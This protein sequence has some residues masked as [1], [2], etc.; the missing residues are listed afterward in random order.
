MKAVLPV[1]FALASLTCTLNP[2]QA[3]RRG[4]HAADFGWESNYAAGLETARRTGRPL[5]VVF[6]C[7]P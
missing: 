4:D 5:M 3:Q 6:R 7:V 2:A 1:A